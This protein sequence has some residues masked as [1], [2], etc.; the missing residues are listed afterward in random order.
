MSITF[1]ATLKKEG[2]KCAETEAAEASLRLM[3]N[4][5]YEYVPC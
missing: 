1:F 2:G 5:Q 4:I 3:L